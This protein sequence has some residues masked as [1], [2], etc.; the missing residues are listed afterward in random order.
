MSK[1]STDFMRWSEIARELPAEEVPLPRMPLHVLF[2]ESV[3]VA[4]F[5]EKYYRAVRD[6]SGAV[7]H[8]GLESVADPTGMPR[9]PK[10]ITSKTAMEILSLQ[11]A[12][13][14]AQTRYLL[15][16]EQRSDV[17]SRGRFLHGELTATLTYHFDDGVEDEKDAQLARVEAAHA[18]DPDTALALASSLDDYAALAAPYRKELD[19]LGGFRAAYIDEARFVAEELRSRPERLS[20]MKNAS[21]EALLLRNRIVALLAERMSAVRNAARFVFR[22][23]P[24]VIREVT[25]TYQRR[26]RSEARRARK[27]TLPPPRSTQLPPPPSA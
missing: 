9:H 13:Q 1:P 7:I 22:D 3:E 10:A 15:M 17:V 18:R 16:V 20:M 26:R 27:S 24:D 21:R 19:G 14:E 8:A 23:R 2:G 4:R 5:F 6:D 11:R 25:S 12:A